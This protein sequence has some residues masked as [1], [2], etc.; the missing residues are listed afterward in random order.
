MITLR[1]P[2]TLNQNPSRQPNVPPEA[3]LTA[4]EHLYPLRRLSFLPSHLPLPQR[5]KCG[6]NNNQK[7]WRNGGT[8]HCFRSARA[9]LSSVMIVYFES[10]L[11]PQP[12][13]EESASAQG[14]SG[15]RTS[16]S[17][18]VQYVEIG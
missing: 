8:V 7:Q 6:K 13:G 1:R 17:S 3:K 10:E 18:T 14:G 15:T 12:E 2:H 5:N 9:I 16:T 11:L 4:P